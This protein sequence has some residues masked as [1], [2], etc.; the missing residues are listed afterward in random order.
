MFMEFSCAYSCCR[1]E[2]NYT[3][4]MV[5][6]NYPCPSSDWITSNASWDAEQLS[7]YYSNRTGQQSTT[8]FRTSHSLTANPQVQ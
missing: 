3:D 8:H 7:I 1:T 2:K 5:D 6:S 4:S